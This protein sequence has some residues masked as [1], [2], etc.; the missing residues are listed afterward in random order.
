MTTEEY[1]EEPTKSIIKRNSHCAKSPDG[2][3]K[4]KPYEGYY[5]CEHCDLLTNEEILLD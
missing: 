3:H 5:V 4:W 1:Q 2:K